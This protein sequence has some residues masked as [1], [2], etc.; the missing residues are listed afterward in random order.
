MA[1][2]LFVGG[3]KREAKQDE[4]AEVLKKAF[5]EFGEVE[6]VDV[7]PDRFTG[8]CKGFAFVKMTKDEEAD[9]AIAKLNDSVLEGITFKNLIVNEARPREEKSDNRGGF[10]RGGGGFNRGG[11]NW[12]SR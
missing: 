2:N 8:Q 5:S 12:Q 3:I 6:S 4:V 1:K 9:A 11:G 10:N 7:I